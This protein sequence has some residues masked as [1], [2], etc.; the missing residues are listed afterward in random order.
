VRYFSK[1]EAE[2]LIP[3]I[4]AIFKEALAIAEKAQAKADK[5]RDLDDDPKKTA[6]A[7]IQ[8]AQVQFLASGINAWLQKIVDMGASPKGLDPALVDFPH[9]LDGREVY[10]CWR[11]GE[12]KI[13][14]Y[15]GI[16]E[17]FAGRKP[18]PGTHHDA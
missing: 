11:L 14:H 13:T 2:A 10:L 7:A 18:L 3:E 16:D 12:K 6:D 5:L 8:R 4:E 9:R 1:A 15:H 17:G